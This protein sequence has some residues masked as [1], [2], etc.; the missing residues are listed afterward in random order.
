M[1]YVLTIIKTGIAKTRLNS[2]ITPPLPPQIINMIEFF[3]ILFSFIGFFSSGSIPIAT[4]HPFTILP[5]KKLLQSWFAISKISKFCLLH[6]CLWVTVG[7]K[8]QQSKVVRSFCLLPQMALWCTLHT[9]LANLSKWVET[10][11][12]FFEVTPKNIFRIKVKWLP[13][14][15]LWKCTIDPLCSYLSKNS[16]LCSCQP[17]LLQMISSAFQGPTLE[18]K[19]VMEFDS[20]NTVQPRV[21]CSHVVC[22]SLYVL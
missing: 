4:F 3:S 10:W 18:T 17:C 11:T 8:K 2:I 19:F 12:N 22:C 7:S 9:C 14:K 1:R 16:L 5:L 6:A 15:H 21:N 13:F 20:Y